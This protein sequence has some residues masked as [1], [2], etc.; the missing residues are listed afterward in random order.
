MR[1]T[2]FCCCLAVAGIYVVEGAGLLPALFQ[3]A[4][5][6]SSGKSLDGTVLLGYVRILH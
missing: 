2:A 5:V 6:K 1:V 4:V 3:K